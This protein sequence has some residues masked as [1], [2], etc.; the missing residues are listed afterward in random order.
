MHVL[1][2]P[3][4]AYRCVARHYVSHQDG[5]MS[6]ADPCSWF[7]VECSFINTEM[8]VTGVYLAHNNLVGSLPDSLGH[9]TELTG[10]D[11]G[12]NKLRYGTLY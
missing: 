10:L 5:W 4:G 12:V 8:R 11:V 2:V 6:S 7:G 3:I 1:L 9:L